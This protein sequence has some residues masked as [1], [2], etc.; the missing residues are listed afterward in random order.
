MKE[1]CNKQSDAASFTMK[2]LCKNGGNESADG[3]QPIQSFS[4]L[5]KHRIVELDPATNAVWQPAGVSSAQF[6]YELV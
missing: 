1:R 3:G 5:N 6:G 2:T 4:Y